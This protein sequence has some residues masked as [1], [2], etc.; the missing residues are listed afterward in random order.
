MMICFHTADAWIRTDARVGDPWSIIRLMG[1]LAAPLFITL[2][3]VSMGLMTT[4]RLG[5]GEDRTVLIQISLIRGLQIVLLGY[6]LRLQ[7]WMIDFG[8]IHDRRAWLPAASLLCAYLLAYVGIGCARRLNYAKLSGLIA[9]SALFFSA[10]IYQVA[11]FAPHRVEGILRVDI[12]QS[13]GASLVVLSIVG[14]VVDVFKKRPYV[15]LLLGTLVAFA[16]PAVR[17]IVPGPLPDALASYLAVWEP[18]PGRRVVSNFPLFPWMAYAFFGISIGAY[19]EQ[20]KNRGRLALTVVSF[21]ALGAVVSFCCYES[22]PFVYRLMSDFPFLTQPIR[23]FY[24]LGAVLLVGGF[25][26]LLSRPWIASWM[27]FRT[28]GCASL[29]IYWVHLEFAYGVVSKPVKLTMGISQ[30][31]WG[32]VT[33]TAVMTFVAWLRLR[34][35][36]I[37]SWFYNDGLATFKHER[38]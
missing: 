6:L 16:T 4:A 26:L 9:I 20:A 3:G 19:W 33:L 23:V 34:A 29:L 7:M 32:F 28:L 18:E 38:S 22:H 8:A 27:P 14:W 24:R 10:G 2:A 21:S 11:L 37:G 36:S 35:A 1:G 5:R 12:L 30:W 31:W 17:S 25:A 15:G 13:I